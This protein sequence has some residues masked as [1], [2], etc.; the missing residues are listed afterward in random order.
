MSLPSRS[1]VFAVISLLIAVVLISINVVSCVS[2]SHFFSSE[3]TLNNDQND[4]LRICVSEEPTAT[5]LTFDDPN[6]I[7]Q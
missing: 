7:Q 2:K 6:Q 4:A 3:H 1:K 5:K